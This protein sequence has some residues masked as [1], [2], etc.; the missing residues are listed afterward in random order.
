MKKLLIIFLAVAA[1][2]LACQLPDADAPISHDYGEYVTVQEQVPATLPKSTPAVTRTANAD[3]DIY[4]DENEDQLIT[5]ALLREGYLRDDVPLSYTLQDN[6]Q[7]FC[8]D[9]NVPYPLIL[10]VIQVESNF[11]ETEDNGTCRGLLQLHRKY[12]PD[13]DST[14]ENLRQGVQ[15]LGELYQ[16]YGN[17]PSALC[18]YNNGT[19]TGSRYYSNKVINAAREWGWNG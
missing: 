13:A 15:F 2:A 18:A 11:D 10:G 19:D 3:P 14:L 17:W 8:I 6:L 4:P 1:V 5:E 9:S 16:K 12:F 7:C